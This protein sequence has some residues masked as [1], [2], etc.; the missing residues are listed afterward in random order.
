MDNVVND[1]DRHRFEL[2]VDGHLAFIDYRNEGDRLILV[3]TE[4]P[5]A[6]GGRGIGTIL[7]RSALNE[8]RQRGHRIVPQCPFV[9]AFI[10]RNPEFKDLLVR[11]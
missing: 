11:S 5:K 6:L 10:E 8:I 4:V 2:T 3:H 1:I 7:V 9:S